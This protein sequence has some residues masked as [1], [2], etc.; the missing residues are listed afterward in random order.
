MARRRFGLRLHLGI[1]S[2][3]SSLSVQYQEALAAAESALAQ[4]LRVVTVADRSA[5]VSP[6]GRL[7]RDLA[8]RVEERPDA[9]KARF[10]RYIDAIAAHCGHRLESTRLHLE[11]GFE[12]ILEGAQTAG[13]IDAAL[14]ERIEA[15]AGRSASEATTV[16]DLVAVYRRA[17]ADLY[18]A[19]ENPTSAPREWRL[20][21]AEQYMRQHYAESAS[22]ARV[23]RVAGFAPSYFSKLFRQKHGFTFE[24]HLLALR[25][26][27]AKQLLSGTDL[28]LQRVAQ[29]CGFSTRHHFGMMFRRMAQETPGRYRARYKGTFGPKGGSTDTR[30]RRE[31]A[32][33]R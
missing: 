15:A 9:R 5:G 25:I 13:A 14:V 22:L 18:E 27:R 20:R 30:R 4:G 28:N 24:Q 23:A 21:R 2:T 7:R 31:G 33:G 8:A 1:G 12:R 29:L 16:N 26:D 17:V 10:E 6:L 32:A 3:T 19:A 11:A